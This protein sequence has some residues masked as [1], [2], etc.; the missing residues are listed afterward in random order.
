[1][2][3]YTCRKKG[4]TMSNEA[5]N[6]FNIPSIQNKK[7][8]SFQQNATPSMQGVTIPQGNDTFQH[9][10]SMQGIDQTSVK[11]TVDNSYLANRAK[12]SADSNP[13]AVGGLTAGLWYAISQGMDKGN[14]KFGGEWD[15]SIHG[16]VGAFGDKISGTKLG[17]KIDR[18]LRKLNVFFH[19]LSKKSKIVY[20]LRNHATRPENAFAK[21]PGKG[22]EGFLAMDAQQIIDEFLEPMAG[23]PKSILGFSTGKIKNSFQK[24]ENYGISQAEIDTLFNSVKGKPVM[25]QALALQKRELIALGADPKVI[26]SVENARGFTGLQKFAEGLKVRLL[27]FKNLKEYNAVKGKLMDNPKQAIEIFEKMSNNPKTANWK[28][29]I[30]RNNGG[31]FSKIK[32]HLFGRTV[33]FSEYRNKYYATIGKG[34]KTKLGKALNKAVGWITEGFTNR[35]AGGKFAVLMQAGIFAEILY[36]TI[37]APKGEKFKT[38]M[39]RGVNDFTY[40]IALTLGIMGMHKVGGFKYAGLDNKGREAYRKALEAFNK[41]ADAGLFKDKKA[42]KLA[43]KVLNKQLGTKNIKNPITKLLQKIGAFINIGNERV[44]AYKSTSKWNMNLLRK[45][46]NGNIIGIPMR[47][48]IP[49]MVVSPFL[50]KLTTTTCHKIFGRPT[51]SVLDEGKE[52]TQ[53]QEQ[54]PQQ[55]AAQNPQQKP[56]ITP[57]QTPTNTGNPY[58][59]RNPQDFSDSNLIKQTLNGTKTP[60]RTYIPSPDCQIQNMAPA[61]S[62]IP[63]PQGVIQQNPDM[64]AADQA[65][66]QADMAEKHIHETL[67]SLNKI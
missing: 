61:R 40:F 25:E 53:A 32:N 6:G 31:I 26:A 2:F 52:E 37:I 4:K 51:H 23:K 12:A 56:E 49:M 22:V 13:L 19:N 63:S 30:W 43:K 42:Y 44:H 10:T 16:R 65:L 7:P 1:M 60:T 35:Y 58:Q 11:Q 33:S 15:K 45:L 24:L 54:N 8:V 41:K 27:G 64:T 34:A 9:S 36:Q 29:S 39:E 66:A 5:I 20:S 47:I 28:V 57:A 21:T 17:S 14:K 38:L 55:P 59:P 50:A 67:A 3:L 48:A 18:G 46:K 62:Y